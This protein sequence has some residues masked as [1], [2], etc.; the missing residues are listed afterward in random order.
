MEAIEALCSQPGTAQLSLLGS[1]FI[2][3]SGD[4]GVAWRPLDGSPAQC[5]VDGSLNIT[6]SG[7]FVGAFPASCPYVTA[8]GGTQVKTGKSVRGPSITDYEGQLNTIYLP[9]YTIRK[10]QP[11]TIFCPC[12]LVAGSPTFSLG[13]I[14]S[15]PP[16]PTT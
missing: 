9:R 7:A 15:A 11:W 14:S 4:V 2:A 10:L 12:L 13:H 6:S 5:L 16:S 1:T 3:S 8:V